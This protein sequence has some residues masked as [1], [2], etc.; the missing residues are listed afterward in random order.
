MP[1]PIALQ[2]TTIH[3]VIEQQGSWFDALQF[4]PTL[5]KE[6]LDENRSWLEPAFLDPANG[7][8]ILCIQSLSSRRRTTT[9]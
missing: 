2:D 7:G 3:P 4:F 6:L 8:L 1:A 9:S 5:T